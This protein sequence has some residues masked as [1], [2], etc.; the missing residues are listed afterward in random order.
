MFAG[1]TF[2]PEGEVGAPGAEGDAG[3]VGVVELEPRAQ[4][5][6]RPAAPRSQGNTSGLRL[7]ED[8]HLPRI[9]G[10]SGIILD[11]VR[12]LERKA[13]VMKLIVDAHY[14]AAPRLQK[15]GVP[16]GHST[17][18]EVEVPLM[19]PLVELPVGFS[20]SVLEKDA[21][22]NTRHRHHVADDAHGV[23]G[24]VERVSRVDQVECR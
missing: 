17:D 23:Y 24:V 13:Q 5:P 1:V 2:V 9:A 22:A 6:K 11:A 10:L 18:G 3:D 15:Q 20:G 19:E 14:G 16:G 7:S 21:A 4:S 8:R 12:G